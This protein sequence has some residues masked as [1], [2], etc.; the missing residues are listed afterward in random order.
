MTKEEAGKAG[1]SPAQAVH[2]AVDSNWVGF[3]A[4]WWLKRN[5]SQTARASPSSRQSE[6]DR[7]INEFLNG[8]PPDDGNTIDMETIR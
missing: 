2:A 6:S 5:G 3:K 8:F 7:R 1:L 4:D